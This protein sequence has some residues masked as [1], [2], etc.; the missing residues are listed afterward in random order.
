MRITTTDTIEQPTSW[1]REEPSCPTCLAPYGHYITCKAYFPKLDYDPLHKTVMNLPV[2][3][4]PS[5]G[6]SF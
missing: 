3:P 1:V 4:R 2:P 5:Q 6:G